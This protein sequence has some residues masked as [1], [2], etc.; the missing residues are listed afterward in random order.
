MVPLHDNLKEAKCGLTDLLSS[1]PPRMAG[2]RKLFLA[3][4][5]A[6]PFCNRPSIASIELVPSW[7][8]EPCSL[9]T[10]QTACKSSTD[11]L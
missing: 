5:P 4:P 7:D 6:T 8:A 3:T 1:D 2:G 11:F 9:E 10:M